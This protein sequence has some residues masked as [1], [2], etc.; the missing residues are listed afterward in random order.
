MFLDKG[1]STINVVNYVSGIYNQVVILYANETITTLISEIFVWT[2]ADPY[3]GLSGSSAHLNDFRVNRP[4]IDGDLGHLL[5]TKSIN[6]GGIAYVDVL[7]NNAYRY[8][9]S[10]IDNTYSNFPT[11]SWTVMVVTHEMGHNLGSPHTQN[12][13]WVGGALDNCYT[14]EGGCPPGPAPTTGGTIM[15][16]CHLASYGINFNNGFGTQ[17]GDLIRLRVN[18]ANCIDCDCIPNI[19]I[20]HPI[21]T[22]AGFVATYSFGGNAPSFQWRKNGINVGTNSDTYID[23]TLVSGD[24]LDVILTSNALCATVTKDTSNLIVVSVNDCYCSTSLYTIGC[25]DGT[26]DQIDDLT[27]SNLNHQNSGCSGGTDGYGDF[28]TSQPIINLIQGVNYPWTIYCNYPN[29]EFVSIWVDLNDNTSFGD[30][31]ELIFQSMSASTSSNLSG[32]FVMPL[33]ANPGQHTLR[34]RLSYGGTMALPNSCTQYQ[35]GETHDYTCNVI[36]ALVSNQV[37]GSPFCS[38]ATM[39]VSYSANITFNAGNIFTAQL[40]DA[41]G[42]FASP[43]NIGTL[44]SITS[45]S[46][47]S[48]IPSNSLYGTG[49]RIRVISSNPTRTSEDNGADLTILNCGVTLSLKLYIEGYYSGGGMMDNFGAGGCLFVN[50]IPHA[51]LTDADTVTVS[52]MNASTHAEV[53]RKKAILK[54]NGNVNII[55]NASVVAGTQYYLKI[56]HRNSLETWSANTVPMNAITSYDFTTAQS[57]AYGNNLIQTND[58]TAWAIYSGDISSAMSGLGNQDGIIEGQD[59]SDMENAVYVIATGYIPADI[60]GDG[61]VEGADYS[62][63]ENNVFYVLTFMRP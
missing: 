7:C 9:F 16:Y 42:S 15:S 14:T 38:G 45:G 30:P 34:I 13:G 63:I 35:Y 46:I 4:V 41:L 8:A 10:N 53:D 2:S 52:A 18:A 6:V 51:T 19:S 33:T 31:G 24:Q 36:G 37:T 48:V 61:I 23:P 22:N 28:R 59:Y 1:S 21:C 49:Y 43:V 27:L 56:N 50:G 12:C 29:S 44:T 60:T 17:P 54:T 62:M 55:F 3:I 47:T 5:S 11:Y 25:T 32:A 20:T 26:P 40:S 39:N 58:Q 57:K